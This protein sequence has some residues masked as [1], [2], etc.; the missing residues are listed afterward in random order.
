MNQ[1]HV[2]TVSDERL[3]QLC[4]QYKPDEDYSGSIGIGIAEMVYQRF[5]GDFEKFR[6]WK[7]LMRT[8]KSSLE[9]QAYLSEANR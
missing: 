7:T 8:K 2:D 6:L 9:K 4:E 3:F 5:G 1:L